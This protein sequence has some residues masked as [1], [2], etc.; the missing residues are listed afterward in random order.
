MSTIKIENNALSGG[1]WFGAWLFTLG[2]LK[3]SFF[4]GVLALLLW[5]YYLGAALSSVGAG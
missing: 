3:L 5:P 4:Q 2:Y 1:L